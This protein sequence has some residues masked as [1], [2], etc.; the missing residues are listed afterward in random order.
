MWDGTY[1]GGLALD[2]DNH[3]KVAKCFNHQVRKD[4]FY[5]GD[6]RHEQGIGGHRA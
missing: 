5:R 4:V 2:G 3:Q 1:L 6:V